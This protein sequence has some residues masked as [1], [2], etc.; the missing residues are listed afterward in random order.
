[1]TYL[2]N[3][4]VSGYKFLQKFEEDEATEY[5]YATNNDGAKFIIRVLKPEFSKSAEAVESFINELKYIQ[6]ENISTGSESVILDYIGHSPCAI[7]K[8]E[9]EPIQKTG[10]MSDNSGFVSREMATNI[11]MPK[12]FKSKMKVPVEKKSKS[13]LFEGLKNRKLMLLFAVFTILVI[14][15]TS[16]I[17]VNV[18]KVNM[19]YEYMEIIN[20]DLNY[21]VA[22]LEEKSNS[23]YARIDCMCAEQ[24]AKYIALSNEAHE[25]EASTNELLSMI[26]DLKSEIISECGGLDK[27]HTQSMK[28]KNDGHSALKV[29]NSD[30]N[31]EELVEKFDDY[32]YLLWKYIGDTSSLSYKVV[33]WNLY[34]FVNSFDNPT[35]SN[36]PNT[37]YKDIP[38]IGIFNLLTQLQIKILSSEIETLT[39]MLNDYQ[40]LDLRI[41][42][43]RGILIAP[44]STLNTGEVYEAQIAMMAIDT[45]MNPTIYYSFSEPFYDSTMIENDVM[46]R[47]KPKIKYDTVMPDENGKFVLKKQCNKPG[48]YKYG[49]LIHYVSNKGEMWLPFVGEYQVK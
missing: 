33:D 31:F 21:S 6:S 42:F 41:T 3:Q 34:Y 13:S 9:E 1:M 39:Y 5:W 27:N 15:I 24:P 35:S 36:N 22:I 43:L 49:G 11:I 48:Q 26:Y 4:I 46:Y 8:F 28:D 40:A 47:L 14:I 10:E 17:A 44:R 29:L 18:G 16:I 12:N 23:I 2:L 30:S 20:D 45:T 7:V 19:D 32:R 37:V 25:V 38:S